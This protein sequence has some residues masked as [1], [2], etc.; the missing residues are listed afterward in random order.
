MSVARSRRATAVL[1]ALFLS[2]VVAV[3]PP[4]VHAA[5][6]GK[7]WVCVPCGLPCDAT[8]YDQPGTCPKCGMALVEASTVAARAPSPKVAVV[9]FDGVEIID[10]TGP[11]EFFGAAGYD[12]YSVASR[13]DPVVTAMGLKLV[14]DHGIADAPM[15]DIL[16]VPGGGVRTA[17]ADSA[18]LAWIRAANAHDQV[19][20]SVCNGAFILAQAGLLDGLRATTTYGNMVRL[21]R[22]FPRVQVVPGQRY[23]D[24]GHILTTAGLSAGMDGAL[25]VIE[26]LKGPRDAHDV[27]LSEEYPWDP[28]G[29]YTRPV[30]ADMLIPNIGPGVLGETGAWNQDRS[31][32]D[33][34]HWE[35]VIH[36]RSRFDARDLVKSLAQDL[37]QRQ[38]W[39][40][41]SSAPAAPDHASLSLLGL[42]GRNWNADVAARPDPARPGEMSVTLRLE[43]NGGS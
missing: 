34:G 36:G 19:T 15:P 11:W 32:G 16:V 27:A 41:K 29:G 3:S 7:H 39:A 8:E 4:A 24:N 9:V 12:V 25:H 43:R 22:S 28:A 5:S 21:A 10:S 6:A 18:L 40:A 38:G 14:P 17:T 23:V 30:L 26:R 33:E 35:I 1:V 2:V 20:M 42:D 31:E 13:K 37:E